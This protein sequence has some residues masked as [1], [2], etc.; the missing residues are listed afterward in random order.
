MDGIITLIVTM[1][2]VLGVNINA[3]TTEKR[4]DRTGAKP[5]TLIDAV[6]TRLSGR[7]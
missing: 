4:L 6:K 3:R 1:G 7:P 5:V 2:T